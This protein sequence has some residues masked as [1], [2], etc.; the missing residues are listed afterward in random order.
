MKR[1]FI[2]ILAMVVLGLSSTFAQDKPAWQ[3]IELT[4]AATLETFTFADFEGKTVFVEPMATWCSNCRTQLKNVQEASLQTDDSVVYI[5]LSV[6]GNLA[7]EK[8]AEYAEREGFPFIFAVASTELLQ[9]L[10][11]DFGRTVTNPPATPHFII[12]ADGSF[13]ELV[14]G[15]ESAE[16]LLEQIMA[17]N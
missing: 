6:E 3:T 8:L 5:A 1:M 17:A 10:V 12:N 13:G 4:N 15:R 7:N 14:T 11:E 16:Q 2:P 9:A